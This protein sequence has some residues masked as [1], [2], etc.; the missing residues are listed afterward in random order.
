MT[1]ILECDYKK[2]RR[3]EF[4]VAEK[5]FP[6]LSILL[7][8]YNIIDKGVSAAINREQKK[9]RDIACSKGCSSCCTTHND[10]PVYPLELMAMSWYVIEEIQ[11]PLRNQ[12]KQQLSQLEN[13]TSCPFLIEGACSIHPVRPIACRQ[14]NVLDKACAEGEDAFHSRKQ[15]VMLPIQRYTDEAF[16]VMLPFYGVTRKGER[17][18][19]IK[20]GRLHSLA[21]VMRDCNWSTLPEKMAAFEARNFKV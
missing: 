19:A 14:F 3:L 16:D 13:V 11:A 12:L 10:I 1:E 9:G 17:K 8:A 20:Q 4:T 2:P 7:N 6:W 18:K 15:D 5:K 21:K